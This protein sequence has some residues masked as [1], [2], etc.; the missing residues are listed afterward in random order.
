MAKALWKLE[1]LDLFRGLNAMEIQEAARIS[2]KRRYNRGDL[3]ISEDS[4]RDVFVLIEGSVEIVSPGNVPLYRVSR[5][6]IFGEL[7]LL[8]SIKRT[9]S[10][11]C[12][13][14]SWVLVMNVNHLDSLGDEHPHI[15]RTI[16]HNLVQSLGVKLARANKLIELL[17]TELAR[18]IKDNPKPK[19]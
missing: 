19:V 8:P 10:A 15:Y 5:G 9:A 3:V 14:D 4:D 7:A 16:S 1:K 12:R 17:K 13:E 18:A 11:V 6:E 2:N